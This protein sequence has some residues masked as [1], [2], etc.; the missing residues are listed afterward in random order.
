MTASPRGLLVKETIR[1]KG[2]RKNMAQT[3][4]ASVDNAALSLISREVDVT[5]AQEFRRILQADQDLDL[6][7]NTLMMTAVSRTLP[8]HPML[9]AEMLEKEILVYEDVNL[10]MAVATPS[11]L[12]VVVIRNANKLTLEAMSQTIQELADRARTGKL[13]MQ[14]VEG[15]TFTASNLGMFGIDGGFPIPRT[16]EGAIVLIGAARKKPWVVDDAISVRHIAT[17]SL[18]FDHRFIDGATAA[19]FLKEVNELISQPELLLK[20]Q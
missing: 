1:L 10:G 3:M 19:L 15:G 16:P 7:L 8:A 11:G 17:L 5:A 6:S 13:T 18:T 9:N 12:V 14:D 20:L 4:K 2:I